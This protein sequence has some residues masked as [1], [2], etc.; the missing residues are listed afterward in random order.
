MKYI[1][2]QIEEIIERN[3]QY[4]YITGTRTES[5]LGLKKE[6]ST[7]IQKEREG[8]YNTGF[9]EGEIKKGKELVDF[10]ENI[11]AMRDLSQTKGG[12]ESD[13]KSLVFKD[14][15]VLRK[16]PKNFVEVDGWFIHKSL[17]DKYLQTKGGK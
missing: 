9:R 4:D 13:V 6:L 12:G 10:Y 2:E 5:W 3:F 7:L 17:I 16:C 15:K 11:L 1:D 14:M 8:S